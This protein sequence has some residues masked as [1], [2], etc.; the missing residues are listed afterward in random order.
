[1]PR[2]LLRTALHDLPLHFAQ[3]NRT[4]TIKGTEAL[5]AVVK[6]GWR[7]IIGGRRYIVVQPANVQ[8]ALRR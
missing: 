7:L 4:V 6:D 5:V 8:Q 2:A 3:L 1:M